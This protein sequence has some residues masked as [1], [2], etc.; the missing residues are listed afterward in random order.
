MTAHSAK[1]RLSFMFTILPQIA[2]EEWHRLEPLE[3]EHGPFIQQLW[4]DFRSYASRVDVPAGFVEG[5]QIYLRPDAV[6][7]RSNHFLR[8][9]RLTPRE[10][11]ALEL[12]LALME[13]ERPPDERPA[14][15]R[16]RKLLRSH[17]TASP[18]H[19]I[20]GNAP[21]TAPMHASA[22]AA[23]NP[24]T[25]TLLK[26]AM[27]DRKVTEIEY[28]RSGTTAP[29]C[30]RVHPYALRADRGKWM[31]WAWCE[32]SGERKM[33]RV[34]RMRAARATEDRFE[35]P[36]NAGEM[37]LLGGE[38]V[39]SDKTLSVK[40]TPQVSQWIGERYTGGASAK[41]SGLTVDHPLRD[42]SWAV[43]H[44]LQYG[45]DAVVVEPESI[46]SAIRETLQQLLADSVDA[47]LGAPAKRSRKGK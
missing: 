25:V 24:K 9:V 19:T 2:D 13:A 46:R 7:I 14:I 44:V 36:A 5:L 23:G 18:T 8:P 20:Q 32:R 34:D 45:P 1:D 11:A 26:R 6:S 47:K 4:D 30:R 40:Y 38:A 27:R 28:Q 41:E 10:A 3:R 29:S 39:A 33:F 35:R 17:M 37:P 21:S 42:D 12:G 16:V 43:R 15:E 31:L 22:A